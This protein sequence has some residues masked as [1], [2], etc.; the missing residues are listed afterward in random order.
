MFRNIAS[1]RLNLERCALVWDTTLDV[2]PLPQTDRLSHCSASLML[3]STM[4]NRARLSLCFG[5]L[6]PNSASGAIWNARTSSPNSAIRFEHPTPSWYAYRQVAT[7]RKLLSR[8]WTTSQRAKITLSVCIVILNEYEVGACF[9][10]QTSL[11]DCEERRSPI[12]CFVG[13]LQD[14]SEKQCS[15]RASNREARYTLR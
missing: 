15:L 7:S 14:F 6:L 5:R 3:W 13:I 9:Q 10:T 12:S 1:D 2:A 11:G 4:R 8:A